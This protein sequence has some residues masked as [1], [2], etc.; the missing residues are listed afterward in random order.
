MPYYGTVKGDAGPPLYSI[1]RDSGVKTYVPNSQSYLLN[2]RYAYSHRT[3]RYKGRHERTPL[4]E[5]QIPYGLRKKPTGMLSYLAA[6]KTALR[7]LSSESEVGSILGDGTW[8][9]KDAGHVF[10]TCFQ[11]KTVGEYSFTLDGKYGGRSFAL[12][13]PFVDPVT[14][15]IMRQTT[16]TWPTPDKFVKP[17]LFTPA[18]VT[19]SELFR[20]CAAVVLDSSPDVI[21]GGIGETLVDLIQLPKLLLHAREQVLKLKDAE[22]TWRRLSEAVKKDI[23]MAFRDPIYGPKKL[24]GES[25]SA[26]LRWSFVLRPLI[27]DIKLTLEVAARASGSI[28]QSSKRLRRVSEK[29]T[30][31]PKWTSSPATIGGT[32]YS[33]GTGISPSIVRSTYAVH[34]DVLI[35]SKWRRAVGY[36]NG[37][38]ARAD[39]LN[40]QLGVI[41][42]SL[43]WDLLPWSFVVDWFTH[44]GSSIDRAHV[45][46]NGK[47][48]LDYSWATV[49]GESGVMIDAVTPFYTAKEK[50]SFSG[51]PTAITTFQSRWPVDPILGLKPK[52]YSLPAA[53]RLSAVALGFSRLKP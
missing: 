18:G 20:E 7:E 11:H 12:V 46:T 1:N 21:T 48:Q 25:A 3:S 38:T 2:G 34:Y 31:E 13:S 26:Y 41:Y 51:V 35:H 44:I 4:G 32:G 50:I 53:A 15:D 10:S 24:T 43:L 19:R 14:F 5:A 36:D 9:I 30:F 42:P 27:D 8:N 29:E 28:Q 37:F 16:F 40:K 39:E 47:F 49:R 22:K 33:D 17:R 23:D 6:E 45:L 52:F